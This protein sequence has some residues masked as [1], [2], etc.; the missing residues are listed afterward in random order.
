MGCPRN[1]LSLWFPTRNPVDSTPTDGRVG[2]ATSATIV[3]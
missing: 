1:S 3:Q 2:P